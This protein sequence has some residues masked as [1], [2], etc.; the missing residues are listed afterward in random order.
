MRTQSWAAT[1]KSHAQV[2]PGALSCR[3]LGVYLEECHLTATTQATWVI[4]HFLVDTVKNCK[5]QQ[6]ILVLNLISPRNY[7]FTA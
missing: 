7:H 6:M 1:T 4:L 3:S 2:L 5:K